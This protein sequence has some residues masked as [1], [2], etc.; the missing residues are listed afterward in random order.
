MLS[1]SIDVAPLR[2]QYGQVVAVAS[3]HF[4][5]VF[6]TRGLITLVDWSPLR[7]DCVGQLNRS[8]VQYDDIDPV[9]LE[10]IP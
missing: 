4:S 7:N 9:C 10:N 5:L 2:T 6:D 3:H 1:T 8:L